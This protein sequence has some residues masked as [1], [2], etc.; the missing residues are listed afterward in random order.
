MAL[1]FWRLLF[2]KSPTQR[3]Q[4]KTWQGVKLNRLSCCLEWL[5]SV[6]CWV[7]AEPKACRY[8]MVSGTWTNSA[9][10]RRQWE[11]WAFIRSFTIHDPSIQRFLEVTYANC[12]EVLA[13][14][15]WGIH[16]C[17]S[18]YPG[19]SVF[20]MYCYSSCLGQTDVRA[21]ASWMMHV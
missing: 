17:S 1:C 8:P 2:H 13:H 20:V 14:G 5:Q 7:A 16:T 21:I 11:W 12:M 3:E 10:G 19:L 6:K 18:Y 15:S 9:P 4:Q